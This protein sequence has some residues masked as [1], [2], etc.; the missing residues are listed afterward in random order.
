MA[1]TKIEWTDY[2]WNPI[3]GCTPISEGCQNCYASKMAKRFKGRFGYPQDD[4]FKPGTFH[5]EAMDK[6]KSFKPGSKVFVCS[7]GDLFHDEASNY[8]IALIYEKMLINKNLIFQLL[9]KRPEKMKN[10]LPQ[11]QK[12]YENHL[13]HIWHGISAENQ[14]CADKRIPILLDCPSKIKFVSCEPLL[15]E[16]DLTSYLGKNKINW[17]IIGGET[18]Q[19]PRKMCP[20]WVKKIVRQ[21]LEYGIP[22]FFKQWG[23]YYNNYPGEN[24]SFRIGKGW[25]EVG[26]IQWKQFPE[27]I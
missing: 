8:D 15:G 10:L 18:G 14:E 9:T 6:L 5:P 16:I 11:F 19:R 1:K 7:M 27:V 25:E 26:D 24:S 20:K 4:L 13:D 23:S 2:T 12:I 21:C 3:T 17:T 22:V